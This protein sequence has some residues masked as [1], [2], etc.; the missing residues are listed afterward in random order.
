L[1]MFKDKE[2]RALAIL[3]CYHMF[4]RY[5]ISSIPFPNI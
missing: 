1:D 4:S 5:F 2:K 3:I